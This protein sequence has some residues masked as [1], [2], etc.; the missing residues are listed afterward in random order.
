MYYGQDL[1]GCENAAT[2]EIAAVLVHSRIGSS[3]LLQP[4]IELGARERE[5]RRLRILCGGNS[6]SQQYYVHN[7]V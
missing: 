7:N 1:R 3:R 4:N 6:T 2:V 5:S